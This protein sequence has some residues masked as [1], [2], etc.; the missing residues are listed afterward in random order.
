[1]SCAQTTRARA[2]ASCDLGHDASDL[3]VYRGL[4]GR[5]WIATPLERSGCELQLPVTAL[6]VDD[7]QER[8]ATGAE[9]SEPLDA[10]ARAGTREH[11]LGD[12]QLDASHFPMLTL[13]CRQVT[14]TPTGAVLTLTVTLRDH[15]SQLEV[16]VQWHQDGASLQASG[17]FTFKQS[18][19]G[20]EP[21]TL[22]LGALRVSDDIRA[23]FRIE[24]R[25]P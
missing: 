17:E 4:Q 12:R 2:W 11:M 21:Y 9:F 23:R 14:T 13:R 25:T 18:A 15:E 6:I 19:L 3:P 16:P 5:V 7:P 10:E 1:M 24:A 22:L 8:S 20:M